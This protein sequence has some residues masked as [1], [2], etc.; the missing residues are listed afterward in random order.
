MSS[1]ELIS[2]I[3]KQWANI[4]DIKKIASCGRDKA[5]FIRNSIIKD[6]TSNGMQ[7]PICKQKLVP[8]EYVINY[9]NINVERL[10]SMAKKEKFLN[11]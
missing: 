8:M 1:L 10:Y 4:D 6:I 5:I 9:F 7:L 2:I 3:S 11:N